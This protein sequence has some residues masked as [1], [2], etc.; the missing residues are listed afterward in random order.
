MN[1]IVK[2]RIYVSLYF[3]DKQR[4]DKAS[5]PYLSLY[6]Y[7]KQGDGYKTKFKGLTTHPEPGACLDL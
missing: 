6:T 4:I 7:G 1:I 2:G 5:S 3:D